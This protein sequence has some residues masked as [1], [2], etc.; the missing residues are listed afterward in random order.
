MFI[1]SLMIN[2]AYLFAHWATAGVTLQTIHPGYVVA[3]VA[4]AFVASIGFS[5]VHAHHDAIAAFGVGVFYWPIL[6]AIVTARLMTA[7]PLPPIIVPSL[8]AFLATAV[9]VT[10]AWIVSHPG[11]TGGPQSLLTGVLLMMVVIQLVFVEEYRKLS[12]SFSFWIFTFPVAVTAN[13]AIRWFAASG[14]GH[15]NAWAWA[16]LVLASAF[17]VA[18]SARTVVLIAG[19]RE[20]ALPATETP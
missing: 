15:W 16:A 14:L 20:Q 10:V 11:P 12:F 17:V 2:S 3:V 8:S 18:I 7:G 6:T 4:G 9:T 1:L 5:S 13:Y 19:R